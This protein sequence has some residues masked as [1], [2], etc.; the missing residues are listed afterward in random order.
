MSFADVKVGDQVVIQP[1][2]CRAG[3]SKICQVERVTATQFTAGGYRFSKGNGR[4]IGC[5]VYSSAT[6]RHSTLELI[7]AVRIEHRYRNAQAKL[8]QKLNSLDTLWREIDRNHDRHTWAATLEKALPYL[9]SAAEVL[10]VQQ[11][12][13]EVRL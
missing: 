7:E 2:S 13:R 12:D 4:Q 8:R 5:A 9:T 10:K 11:E 1:P 6:V 3:R